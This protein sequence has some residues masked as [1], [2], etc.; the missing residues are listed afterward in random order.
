MEGN[1]GDAAVSELPGQSS[2][3][4]TMAAP[5]PTPTPHPAPR[6]RPIAV[7]RAG[8]KTPNCTSHPRE[9]IRGQE[10]QIAF[11]STQLAS[12]FSAPKINK[13][14]DIRKVRK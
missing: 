3:S 2:F 5:P 7:R 13:F 1:D 12:L 14:Q 8:Q 4:E 9:K 11:C 6:T 10:F